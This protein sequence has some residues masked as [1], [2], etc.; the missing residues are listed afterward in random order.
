MAATYT[1]IDGI[2]SHQ[3]SSL[4]TNVEVGDIIDMK[5]VLGRSAKKVQFILTDATDVIEYKLNSLVKVKKTQAHTGEFHPY[6]VVNEVET[7]KIDSG[8]SKFVTYSST[9]SETV[10]TADGLTIESIKVVSLTL[11]TGTTISIVCW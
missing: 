5:D 1:K 3:R 8:A 10:E 9:G 6:N 7:T 11:S 2:P 4:I